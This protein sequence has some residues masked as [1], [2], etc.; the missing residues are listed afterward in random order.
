MPLI[1]EVRPDGRTVTSWPTR[2]VPA[3]IWPAY[4]R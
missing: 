1:R 4:P 3:A 2:N